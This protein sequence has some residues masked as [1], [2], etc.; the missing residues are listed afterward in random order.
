MPTK[1][2]P[3]RQNLWDR[4]DYD[5]VERLMILVGRKAAAIER[6]WRRHQIGPEIGLLPEILVVAT[7][8]QGLEMLRLVDKHPHLSVYWPGR[9]EAY[10]SGRTAC[11]ITVLSEDA[12]RRIADW[13]RRLLRERTLTWGDK[14]L[15][16]ETKIRTVFL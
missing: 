15:W 1:P 2:P 3:E 16:L 9:G 14:S 8:E 6:Y 12:G 5:L 10:L 11:R 13:E 4:R 7:R